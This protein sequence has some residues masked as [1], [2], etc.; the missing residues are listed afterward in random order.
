MVEV[1]LPAVS[2]PHFPRVK[3]PGWNFW[4]LAQL[5]VI[6]SGLCTYHLHY[7]M[8]RKLPAFIS[9]CSVLFQQ[10]PPHLH[11]GRVTNTS[12][13]LNIGLSCHVLPPRCLFKGDG[14]CTHPP[15]LAHATLT[16]THICG[17][18]TFICT[19]SALSIGGTGEPDIVFSLELCSESFSVCWASSHQTAVLCWFPSVSETP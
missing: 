4:Q 10:H 11:S 13:G 17:N 15:S 12:V 1:W 16:S 9:V 18:L 7:V 8:D 3:E 19:F 2:E 5:L 14:L 6:Y